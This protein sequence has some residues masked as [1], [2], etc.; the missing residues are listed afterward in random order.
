MGREEEEG[1]CKERGGEKGKMRCGDG[2]EEEKG[3]EAGSMGVTEDAFLLM[4]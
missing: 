2:E 4:L 1:R 3:E